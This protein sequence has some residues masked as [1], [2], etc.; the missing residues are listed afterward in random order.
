MIHQ[1]RQNAKFIKLN[2][3]L[4]KLFP[5]PPVDIETVTVGI[6]E[7]LW[8]LTIVSA[9][10]GD[11]G[12]IDDSIIAESVGWFGTPIDLINLLCDTG[13]LDT[14]EEYRLVVHDWH[15]HCPRYL[16]R[17]IVR[18]GGYVT[19]K[20]ILNDTDGTVSA[21][22][23]VQQVQ[24]AHIPNITKHNITK[25]N[26]RKETSSEE[27]LRF[28][29]EDLD[30]A[31]EMFALILDNNP[32]TKKPN[33]ESWANTFR[34]MR[35]RDKRTTDQ[36]RRMFKWANNDEFWSTNILSP[37]KLRKHW[38][39]LFLQTQR[40]KNANN[41]QGHSGTNGHQIGPGQRHDPN[42]PDKQVTG[43]GWS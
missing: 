9:P 16:N 8:H 15:E 35:E 20:P 3:E 5:S 13:W 27:T 4:R 40:D 19:S 11:I 25:P 42:R 23:Q 14:S 31:K 34:L 7:R 12:R 10:R 38:E 24:E 6:L 32:A 41:G 28:E 1:A 2:R 39:K 17:S 29:P 22:L 43:F 37:T 26:K 33:L 18:K 21:A 36:I 30:S